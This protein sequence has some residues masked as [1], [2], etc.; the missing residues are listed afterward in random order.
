MGTK[1]SER[2]RRDQPE[3]NPDWKHLGSPVFYAALDGKGFFDNLASHE[4]WKP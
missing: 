1:K 3:R 2:E 4:P